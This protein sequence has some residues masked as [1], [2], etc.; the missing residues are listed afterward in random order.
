MKREKNKKRVLVV[1][2][3]LRPRGRTH[4][5][6]VEEDEDEE[7]E[8]QL[9]DQ[10][11]TR[12]WLAE[13]QSRF[14]DQPVRILVE[15][16]DD[17]GDWA[18]C[19]KYPLSSFDQELVKQEFGGG[20]YR[21]TLFDPK[22]LYI[23]GGRIHF[24]FAE[25]LNKGVEIV[26]AKNPLED[27]MVLM[28]IE[29][30]KSQQAAMM[31]LTKSMFT[32]QAAGGSKGGLV[33]MI[34]AMKSLK[35][36]TP[37]ERPMDNFKETLGMMKLVKEVTGDGESDSKGGLLGDIKDFLEVWPAVKDQLA[38]IKPPA[39]AGAPA[40]TLIPQETK[41][42]MDPLTQKV[43]SLVPKFVEAGKAAAPVPEWGAFLLEMFDTE[44]MPL[45]LPVLQKKYKALVKDEDDVYDIMLRLASDPDEREEIFK[46]IRPLAPHRE[47]ALRVIDEAVRLAQEPD[48]DPQSGDAPVS[49]GGSAILTAVEKNGHE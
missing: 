44:I 47:W 12:E 45:L 6:E 43:I 8:E 11:Q 1:D 4:E 34:E 20:K 13:F 7:S 2:A 17:A 21:G 49:T 3:D 29:S 42:V 36:M 5:V 46:Q 35:T 25:T 10:E 33:E 9:A 26:K 27:P 38:Q 41:P 28:I 18:I 16:Y 23:K 24:K 19:H 22:G 15:K 39:I 31:E 14:T 37:N 32:A 40:Q 30:M 48:V